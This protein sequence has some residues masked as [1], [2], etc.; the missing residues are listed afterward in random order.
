MFMD[1]DEELNSVAVSLRLLNEI[2]DLLTQLEAAIDE[3]GQVN[4][5]VA[6]GV[7]VGHV[8]V[9]VDAVENNNNSGDI[10]QAS[11]AVFGI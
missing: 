8:D 2:Q 6:Q 1:F 5:V 3:R 7:G 10:G 9:Q 11:N 4:Y